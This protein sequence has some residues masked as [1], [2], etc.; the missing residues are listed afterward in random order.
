MTFI[1]RTEGLKLLKKHGQKLDFIVIFGRRRVGK[2]AL[3]KQWAKSSPVAYS[4]ALESSTPLQIAQLFEDFREFLPKNIAVAKTWEELLGSIAL[5]DDKISFV[6]DEFP[7]LVN[8]DPSL[9]SRIQRWFDHSKPENVGLVLLGSSQQ[10]MNSLFLDGSSPLYG[11]A[12]RILHVQPMNYRHFCEALQLNPHDQTSFTIFSM[13][14]GIPRYWSFVNDCRSP[15]EAAENLYF[16]NFP[17]LAEEPDRLLRDEGIAGN[18]ARSVLESIGRGARRPSEISSRMGLPQTSLSKTLQVL[19]QTSLIQRSLP[20]GESPRSSKRTLYH[21]QDPCL[22]FWYEVFSPHQSR[23]SGYSQDKKSILIN[24]HASKL[25][26]TSFRQ[27]H[28]DSSSYW[29]SS[30]VEFDCVRFFDEKKK[31]VVVSEI[32]WGKLSTSQKEKMK[33]Q[34]EEKYKASRLCHQYTL[35]E[36]EVLDFSDVVNQLLNFE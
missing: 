9:P 31:S 33:K 25:L 1:N 32:K 26:E 4:Q 21:I 23:W 13:V 16:G 36:V 24:E 5:V 6:I 8:S 30:L 34:I 7:Y 3:I 35:A 18:N 12:N 17:L 19:M 15:I 27:I 14:G 22:R 2:T 20:F 28:V 11:R 10:M 29:E